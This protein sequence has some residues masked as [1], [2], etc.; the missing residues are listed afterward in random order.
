M[1]CMTMLLGQFGG[2]YMKYIPIG[3]R[4]LGAEPVTS[5]VSD[6]PGFEEA[7]KVGLVSG[8]SERGG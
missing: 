5:G 7:Y 6:E 3:Y 1:Y 4:L 2:M 8:G